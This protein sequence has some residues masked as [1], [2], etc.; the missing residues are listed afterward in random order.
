MKTL[1][2]SWFM[3]SYFPMPLFSSNLFLDEARFTLEEA[4][5]ISMVIRS[6]RLGE[7]SFLFFFT[8]PN[9]LLSQVFCFLNDDV[10]YW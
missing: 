5:I 7:I 4:H 9:K 1:A 6:A 10:L 8:L 2:S 3:F